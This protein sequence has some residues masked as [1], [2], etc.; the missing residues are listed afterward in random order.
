MAHKRKYNTSSPEESANKLMLDIMSW[1]I[2]EVTK[3]N[4]KSVMW[5]LAMNEDDALLL[6]VLKDLRKEINAEKD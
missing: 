6:R 3:D 4:V 2:H 1:V 5:A